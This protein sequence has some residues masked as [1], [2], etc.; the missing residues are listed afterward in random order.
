MPAVNASAGREPLRILFVG[1]LR[2]GGT[3]LQ[4]MRTM[5]ALGHD[6]T[7]I[8]TTGEEGRRREKS[9]VQRVLHRLRGPVDWPGA[10]AALIERGRTG[11]LD[12]LWIDRGLTLTRSTLR[13]FRRLRPECRIAGYSGDPMFL[14]QNLSRRFLRHLGMY[15]VFYTTKSNGVDDLYRRGCRRVVLVGTAYEPGVHRPMPVS[16]AERTRLG[17]S[18]GFV[19]TWEEPRS[20]SLHRLA[21][22]GIP[23]RV[24]GNGWRRSRYRHPLLRVEYRDLLDDD[25]ALAISAFD[26]NLCFL[27]SCDLQTTRSVEIPACGGFMLA[28]RTD[29]H[30]ALFAEGVEAAYFDDDD[31]L[32]AKVR[33]YL[34]HPEERRRIA[35]AGRARCLRD[36]YGNPV[37]IAT[38]LDDALSHP[39][40]SA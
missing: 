36:G 37:R 35:A 10:N 27:R 13:A 29:E 8:D 7:T 5:R 40:A 15:D 2:P 32:L 39:V 18:V 24:W 11:P 23:V 22:A 1:D 26:V 34:D 20:R 25:Y 14:R 3:S 6:V 31:E 12:V 16:D 30:L 21:V 28:E 4:R 19:G 33:Y 17:G 38:M 9:L